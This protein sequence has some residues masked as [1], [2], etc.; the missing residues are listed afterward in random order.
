VH[1]SVAHAAVFPRRRRPRQQ[2]A[3]NAALLEYEV[4]DVT[5]DLSARLVL[6][7]AKPTT[8]VLSA[9]SSV[10]VALTQGDSSMA[11]FR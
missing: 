9:E 7:M 1:S 4:S 5:R 6:G 11:Y 10:C 2:H 3:G 8:S